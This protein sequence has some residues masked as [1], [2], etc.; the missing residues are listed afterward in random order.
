MKVYQLYLLGAL[1]GLLIGLLHSPRIEN[2]ICTSQVNKLSWE[3]QQRLLE[4][5]TPNHAQR[6]LW[7]ATEAGLQR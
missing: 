6:A 1:L 3:A 4:T 7:C 5:T 2:Y